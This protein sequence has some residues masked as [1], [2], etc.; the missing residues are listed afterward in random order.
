MIRLVLLFACLILFGCGSG[1]EDLPPNYVGTFKA[2][3][4]RTGQIA[5]ITI[6][7]DDGTHYEGNFA[8][9]PISGLWGSN[10]I[11]KGSDTNHLIFNFIGV[12]PVS[13]INNV[14]TGMALDPALVIAVRQ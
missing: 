1:G 3:H 4:P 11:S 9:D 12:T 2:V 10:G 7:Q 13:Y 5:I 14:A 8:N 6:T